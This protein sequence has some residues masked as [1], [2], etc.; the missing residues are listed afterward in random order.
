MVTQLRE[1]IQTAE[2]SIASSRQQLSQ[3]RQQFATARTEAE[4]VDPRIQ[5]TRRQLAVATPKTQ[6]QVKELEA[7][8]LAEKEA[9]L[10]QL[11]TQEAAFET[12]AQTVEKQ[13]A[14]AEVS[15][16]EAKDWYKAERYRERLG[17]VPPKES[18]SIKEK[19]QKLKESEI[20]GRERA[21]Q[22]AALSSAGL[23]PKTLQTTDLSTLSQEKLTSLQNVGLVK[24][25]QQKQQQPLGFTEIPTQETSNL[26]SA[27][28]QMASVEA[29]WRSLTPE[30]KVWY[31]IPLGI[32][33]LVSKVR[34]TA[35]VQRLEAQYPILQTKTPQSLVSTYME[36][37]KIQFFSIALKS[38]TAGYEDD[39]LKFEK[40][41][42]KGFDVLGE[43]KQVDKKAVARTE[44][45]VQE[46]AKKK[47]KDI[48]KWLGERAKEIKKLPEGETKARAIENLRIITRGLVSREVLRPPT[49]TI[50]PPTTAL[51]QFA[52]S[53]EYFPSFTP[54]VAGTTDDIIA[55][56]FPTT[57]MELENVGFILAGGTL[58]K[59]KSAQEEGQKTTTTTVTT[60]ITA[61]KPTQISLTGQSSLT[62]QKSIIPQQ[63]VL[64]LSLTSQQIQQPKVTTPKLKMPKPL[65]F[66]KK[67]IYKRPTRAK[68]PK[69][70]T[71]F[72]TLVKRKGVYKAV[73]RVLPKAEAIKFGEGIATRT[74]AASFRVTP[75]KVPVIAA[76]IKD[77]KPSPLRFRGYKI[78]K[79]KKIPLDDE[80]IQKRKFRLS[81]PSEVKEIQMFRKLKGGFKL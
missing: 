54:D 15:V 57:P 47:Q 40:Q 22:M 43:T 8:R 66:P 37:P 63:T 45:I 79:G 12:E 36:Y 65:F 64:Q 20:A 24:I 26:I 16:Q 67:S 49:T 2:R 76:K 48:W 72:R 50:R 60:T 4:A 75:T 33:W 81:M 35:P 53:Y 13:I 25:K 58:F 46:L 74:L 70:T 30:Q 21:K 1:Q 23:T 9:Y 61:Q 55:S 3:Q 7:Q 71:G 77:Y 27:E 68:L 31:S 14:E 38:G 51:K 34:L 73:G 29:S 11:S 69:M 39:I 59:Q 41:R 62:I 17:F 56:F 6:Q 18:R 32:G 42:K 28:E 10:K 44:R 5:Q 78:K 19:F 80:W 52:P